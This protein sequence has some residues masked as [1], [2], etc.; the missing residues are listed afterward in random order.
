MVL[1][2]WCRVAAGVRR[3]GRGLIGIE[4][5]IPG[6]RPVKSCDEIMEIPEAYDLTGSLRCAAA[7]AGCDHPT[8][9][10]HV[11]LRDAGLG[12]DQRGLAGDADR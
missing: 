2:G 12:P 8:V 1:P 5:S 3:R 7:L 6:G 10:D 11:T 4:V 9:G